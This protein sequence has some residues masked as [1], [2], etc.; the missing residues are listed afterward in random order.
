MSLERRNQE[1][2]HRNQEVDISFLTRHKER[3]ENEREAQEA[4]NYLNGLVERVGC[5]HSLREVLVTNLLKEGERGPLNKQDKTVVSAIGQLPI[6]DEG[7]EK[8][9]ELLAADL[10][11]D[12]GSVGFETSVKEIEEGVTRERTKLATIET[13]IEMWG[14]AYLCRIVEYDQDSIPTLLSYEVSCQPF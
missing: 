5:F 6:S 10:G 4:K 3:K 9:M 2:E 13:E 14:E 7:W 11:C 8:G 1:L 12:L